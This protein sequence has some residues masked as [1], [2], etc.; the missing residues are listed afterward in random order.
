MSQH[1]GPFTVT[2]NTGQTIS[3]SVSHFAEG[4]NSTPCT[5]S[6]LANGATAGGGEW[7]TETT[8]TDR[9]AISSNAGSTTKDCAID[10]GDTSVAVTLTSTGVVIV[11]SSSSSCSG[12]Y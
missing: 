5:F 10:S 11:P 1:S 8:S 3:G 4:C 9:W 12:S 2:N 6:N 7:Q